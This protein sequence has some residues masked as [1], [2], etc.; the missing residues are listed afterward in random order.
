MIVGSWM[1]RD[2][3]TLRPTDTVDG[4]L[5]LVRE[6][7]IR[8]LP[9]VDGATLI[10]LV[11]E[12]DLCLALATGGGGTQP[13]SAVM[14]SSLI[15]VGPET[16]IEAAAAL[17]A[18]NKIGSLPVVDEN[19]ALVGIITEYDVLNVFLE[20]MGV[21]SG[22]A[23][24]ELLLPDR[25]G[26]LAGVAQ[27]MAELDVNVLSVVSANAPGAGEKILILRVATEV[28]EPVLGRLAA[29]DVEVLSDEVFE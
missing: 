27:I 3:I 20:V 8:H 7:R 24:L 28:L 17:M 19:D 16:T 5:T 10:G 23:R 12:R 18:E 4:A 15:T 1:T 25:P 13:V 2:P 11:A 9:V 21:G 26:A 6:R 22:S 14:T 29:A